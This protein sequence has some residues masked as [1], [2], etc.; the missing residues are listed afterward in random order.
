VQQPTA[1]VESRQLDAGQEEVPS[2]AVLEE[3]V[4]VQVLPR[5]AALDVDG[6][7]SDGDRDRFDPDRIRLSGRAWTAASCQDIEADH[8]QGADAGV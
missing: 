5:L 7:G 8:R 4:E 6:V 2:G 3:E 1:R